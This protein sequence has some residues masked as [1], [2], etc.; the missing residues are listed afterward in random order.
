[1]KISRKLFLSQAVI[2]AFILMVTIAYQQVTNNVGKDLVTLGDR[3]VKTVSLLKDLRFTGLRIITSTS[4]FLLIASL[5]KQGKT[6]TVRGVASEPDH[7]PKDNEE[8]HEEGSEEGHN[9]PD[10][11]RRHVAKAIARYEEN[12]RLYEEN[13]SVGFTRNF[14]PKIDLRTA[15]E[16][17]IAKSH[18]LLQT[19][20]DDFEPRVILEQREKFEKLERMF[21]NAIGE[22]LEY[23]QHEYAGEEETIF[24][25][26]STVSN[27]GW[28]GFL[29]ISA[30]ILIFGGIVTRAIIRPTQALANGV[31]AVAGGE[32]SVRL[33]MQRSDEIGQVAAGFD[34]MV[35][36]LQEKDNTLNRRISDLNDTR[37]H[38]ANLNTK[39]EERTAQLTV[40]MEQAEAASLAKS[41]FLANMSHELRT[42]MNG[43]LGM[44]GLL[45]DTELSAEQ[46]IQAVTIKQS[47]ETLLWLLNDIL[48]LSKIEADRVELEELNFEIGQLLD[49]LS[50]IWQSLDRTKKLDFSIDVSPDVT[51]VMKGDPTRIRQ[52]LLNLLSNAA[53]FTEQGSVKLAVSQQTQQDGELELRFAVTDTGI[54]ITP[55]AQS[56]LFSNFTQADSSTTRKY[57]G[58]GLGLAISKR[59]AQLMGGKIGFESTPSQGSTFWFT[60]RCTKGDHQAIE[61]ERGLTGI[62]VASAVQ[63]TDRS[64]RILVAEDDPI[65]QTVLRAILAKTPHRF[66]MVSNGVEAVAAAM[67]APYDLVLMDV[68]MPEMDGVTATQKIREL[69]GGVGDIPIIA[70]TANAMIGDRESYLQA[71][72]TDYISKPIGPQTLY[73]AIAKY[74]GPARKDAA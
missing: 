20:G 35:E 16:A 32:L 7:A 15:G 60:V 50:P 9:N 37:E 71:G 72:M 53:K 14:A 51:P 18:A 2:I 26:I 41:R 68:Q 69:P 40:S 39:L 52:I 38:L 61:A 25:G 34:I 70:L 30:F 4:E 33:D 24:A 59:L 67:R 22:A 17:L 29:A 54:G 45:L 11:A 13:N 43:V 21:L 42:P 27:A 1:M 6:E 5:E 66:D 31:K 62:E 65:N 44:A 8:G 46:R 63:K 73:D 48:D 19:A 28:L 55:D 57:G 47:G 12:L 36:T 10:A 3:S 74:S 58:T 49:S 23:Q 56:E 64:L